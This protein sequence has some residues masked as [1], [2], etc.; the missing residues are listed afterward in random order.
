[1]SL[2]KFNEKTGTGTVSKEAFFKDIPEG[3]T[4]ELFTV[5]DEYRE[6]QLSSIANAALDF[7]EKT[8]VGNGTGVGVSINDIPMGGQAT[9]TIYIDPSMK[10]L[11]QV[12][13]KQSELMQ[14]V[15]AR[16][17][18]LYAQHNVS[19]PEDEEDED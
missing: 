14:N 12:D 15:L 16:A 6:K 17:E 19:D 1:M 3:V 13:Y 8:G 4:E 2:V 10:L 5:V 9:G 18:T 11:T 7:A